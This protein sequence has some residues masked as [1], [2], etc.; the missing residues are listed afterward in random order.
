MA[1]RVRELAA[2]LEVMGRDA[3]LADAEACLK[4]LR[5]ELARCLEYIPQLLAEVSRT[6]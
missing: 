3:A 5:D 1:N 6:G 2:Q 4:Q